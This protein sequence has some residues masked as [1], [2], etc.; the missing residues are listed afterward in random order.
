MARVLKL[1]ENTRQKRWI[2]LDLQLIIQ[3]KRLKYL[4]YDFGDISE[5]LEHW[6]H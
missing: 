6:V 4:E 3:S 1:G 5:V 2:S